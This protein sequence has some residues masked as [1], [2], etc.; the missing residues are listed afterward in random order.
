MEHQD[1]CKKEMKAIGGIEQKL[2]QEC[3]NRRKKALRA[4]MIG[5]SN[6]KG[7]S[8]S[9]RETSLDHY[10]KRGISLNRLCLIFY[11]YKSVIN[12]TDETVNIPVRYIV[13]LNRLLSGSNKQDS[14]SIFLLLDAAMPQIHETY[15]I[16]TIIST[17]FV[18]C[19][20]FEKK[21]IV[22]HI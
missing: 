17:L 3:I 4:I 15:G 1:W 12:N 13:Y 20:N 11:I 21:Y 2:K 10:G 9:S 19:M 5:G 8:I 6:L 7:E 22:V 18:K 16:K 14:L